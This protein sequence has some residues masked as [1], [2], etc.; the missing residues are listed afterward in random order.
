MTMPPLGFPVLMGLVVVPATGAFVLI[1]LE[2][3][4]SRRGEPGRPTTWDSRTRSA[5]LGTLMGPALAMVA[6][7]LSG[8]EAAPYPT[9]ATIVRWATSAGMVVAM[10]SCIALG[11]LAPP[12]VQG[13]W[14]GDGP[15]I[16]EGRW[17]K[18]KPS[19]DLFREI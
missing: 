6:I 2:R 14:D 11:M 1:A 4:K 15:S 10:R 7:V 17:K 5:F 9:L 16:S 13:M 8:P 19:D 3:G 12:E 18:G